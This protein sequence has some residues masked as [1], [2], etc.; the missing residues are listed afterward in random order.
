MNFQPLSSNACQRNSCYSRKV[1]RDEPFAAVFDPSNDLIYL[2][3][4]GKGELQT[5]LT[6]TRSPRVCK[7]L[8]ELRTYF[9]HQRSDIHLS[10]QIRPFTVINIF[11]TSTG[12]ST[13]DLLEARL[14]ITVLQTPHI[15]KITLITLRYY[16]QI[17]N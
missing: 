11:E 4:P 9:P 8:Q 13:T 15:V 5:G 10:E 6:I 16:L 2:K 17:P 14:K 7:D 3:V 1:S 12:Y